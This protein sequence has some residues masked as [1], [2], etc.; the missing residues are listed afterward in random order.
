MLKLFLFSFS[1]LNAN[2][3]GIVFLILLID[4]FM[5]VHGSITD[6]LI[7]ISPLTSL[8]SFIT[9]NSFLVWIPFNFQHKIMSFANWDNFT[10][11]LLVRMPFNYFSRLIVL[12]KTSTIMVNKSGRSRHLY[13]YF[14]SDPWVEACSLLL[15]SMM[16]H[17]QF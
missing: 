11:F 7:S 9:S 13:P 14:D 15:L 3:N 16:C 2:I 12:A 10:S 17:I 6:F 5:L 8:N 1:S 4:F